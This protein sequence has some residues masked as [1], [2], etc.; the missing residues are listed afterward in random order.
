C[1]PMA[2]L[3]LALV[4]VA[5]RGDEPKLYNRTV[6][7]WIKMLQTDP[8][9]ERRQ[10]AVLAIEVLGA[11]SREAMQALGKSVRSDADEEVRRASAQL[12]GN[13]GGDARDGLDDLAA[14]VKT[15][16]SPIVREACVN[17]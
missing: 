16:K 2:L 3:G 9:P 10:G 15:E 4:V 6:P 5:G 13:F 11:K 12:L 14:A 8:K 1:W 17:A 7:E